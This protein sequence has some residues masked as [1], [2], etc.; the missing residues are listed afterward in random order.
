M[1][2]VLV[3]PQTRES[4][5]GWSSLMG[6]TRRRE[7][8]AGDGG[9]PVGRRRGKWT[10]VLK[11]TVATLLFPFLTSRRLVT[12]SLASA[13]GVGAGGG[14]R[15]EGREGRMQW[16]REL[17]PPPFTIA[18]SKAARGL[19]LYL[20]FIL[21]EGLLHLAVSLGV[22]ATILTMPASQFR[23]R[24]LGWIT[25][26]CL[27]ALS[28][29]AL[30]A[31]TLEELKSLRA[32]LPSLRGR[33]R[34]ESAIW[35][36][37]RFPML[38]SRSPILPSLGS[39]NT[40]T[41]H[42][43]AGSGT[44]GVGSLRRPGTSDLS[45][46][47]DR[48]IVPERWEERSWEGREARTGLVAV[49]MSRK[50]HVAQ[51][52]HL[53]LIVWWLLSQQIARYEELFKKQLE[54]GSHRPDSSQRRIARPRALP[55]DS[56]LDLPLLTGDPREKQVIEIIR[57]ISVFSSYAV[58]PYIPLL[59]FTL[60][61]LL[62]RMKLTPETCAAFF[63]NSSGLAT[64]SRPEA[65]AL[66]PGR[67]GSRAAAP[68]L[69]SLSGTRV[70]T[71]VSTDSQLDDWEL[72]VGLELIDQAQR[73]EAV[74]NGAMSNTNPSELI[75]TRTTERDD[76]RRNGA[77]VDGDWG[78]SCPVFK[79]DE[80][81]SPSYSCIV[82]LSAFR[83]NEPVSLLP[84]AHIFHSHCVGSWL[85]AHRKCPLRC[86][87]PDSCALTSSYA[88]LR[89][90][91]QSLPLP[92]QLH[93]KSRFSLPD[94]AGPAF[95]LSSNSPALPTPTTATS[96]QA[97]TSIN[98]SDPEASTNDRDTHW[99]GSSNVVENVEAGGPL[100]VRIGNGTSQ[101][102]HEG[103]RNSAGSRSPPSTQPESHLFG[104]GGRR[105]PQALEAAPP[106]CAHQL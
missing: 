9:G 13:G 42:A 71:G 63:T 4:W 69:G 77:Q 38:P 24:A 86:A 58:L 50:L 34:S 91:F 78:Q 46:R 72:A 14:T 1:F 47:G 101:S 67:A 26:C 54:N 80:A 6:R 3:Q 44:L 85:R 37:S 79:W 70:T 59:F 17:R 29:A 23:E 83:Q 106:D 5:A 11:T 65:A 33:R 56:P 93:L 35:P 48:S 73:R 49:V 97:L 81:W 84:C 94:S 89:P 27:L 95:R 45:E 30:L 8:I 55:T 39:L 74:G 12:G 92:F 52:L 36:P 51:V 64:E 41:S 32:R 7:R 103:V 98:D 16:R 15:G 19:L 88:L 57:I 28:R 100:S 60:L 96:I 99:P 20:R 76:W 102:E 31:L 25:F 2:G 82:C 22:L 40:L 43:L 68:G 21:Y 75:E 61:F 62:Y 66:H 18:A 104:V 87:L 10:R 90:N 53:L 105:D